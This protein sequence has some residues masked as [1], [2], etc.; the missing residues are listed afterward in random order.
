MIYRKKALEIGILIGMIFMIVIPTNVTAEET[1][2]DINIICTNSVL[3]DFAENIAPENSTIDYIMP[4]G[5]CPAH[6]DTKPSDVDKII[7]ADVVISLGW[8]PWLEALLNK[9]G[10]EDYKQIICAKNNRWT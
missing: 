9:S 6:F 7:N 3:A 10:N 8:E 5:A 1:N 4:A 2:S